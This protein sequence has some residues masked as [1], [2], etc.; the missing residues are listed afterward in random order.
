M[1]MCFQWCFDH[2]ESAQ[3][4][5]FDCAICQLM[6]IGFNTQHRIL[7]QVFITHQSLILIQAFMTALSGCIRIVNYAQTCKCLIVH[8]GFTN[9][10]HTSTLFTSTWLK[11][12]EIQILSAVGSVSYDLCFLQVKKATTTICSCFSLVQNVYSNLNCII[13]EAH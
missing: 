12:A 8:T 1:L 4:V 13:F 2:L 11:D 6:L 7:Q 5:H 3:V 9:V 10:C